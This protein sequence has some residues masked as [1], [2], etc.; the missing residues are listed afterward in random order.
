MANQ[1][2]EQF[3]SLPMDGILSFMGTV[4]LIHMRNVEEEGLPQGSCL[5]VRGSVLLIIQAE[6]LETGEKTFERN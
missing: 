4:T 3:S 2:E 5:M 1:Q 6:L